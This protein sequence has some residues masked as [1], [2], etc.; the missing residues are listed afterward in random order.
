[1]YVT[2]NEYL[3]EAFE[4]AITEIGAVACNVN[5]IA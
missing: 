1:M 2:A 3:F 4:I 5:F